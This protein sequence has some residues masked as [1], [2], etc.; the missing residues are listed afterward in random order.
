M[1]ELVHVY[2]QRKEEVVRDLRARLNNP[3]FNPRSI[4]QMQSLLFGSKEKGGFGYEPVK[5][6]ERPGRM[7]ADAMWRTPKEDRHRLAPA[8]DTETLEALAADYADNEILAKLVDFKILD[9]V[10][11]T[12]LPS[13][14]MDDAESDDIIYEKG[15]PGML[16]E[17]QR[18]RCTINQMSETGR[19]KHSKPNLAQLPKKQEKNMQELVGS[20]HP[21]IRSCFMATPGWVLVEADYKSAEIYT[22]GYLAD[23]SKLVRDAGSDIHSRGVVNYFGAKAWEGFAE[24]RQ[25]PEEW[26]NDKMNTALRTA[27]KAVTFGC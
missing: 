4:P 21:S 27:S 22:L 10:T 16:S 26:L 7:W 8:T 6:T 15:L 9:Q 2:D 23:C 19:H 14:E 18:I 3:K 13:P 24:G 12:F 25:P 1:I 5:T 11:K 20:E 17:D